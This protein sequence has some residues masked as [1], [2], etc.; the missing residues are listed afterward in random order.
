MNVFPNTFKLQPKMTIGLG[1]PWTDVF[2]VFPDIDK[3]KYVHLKC[4]QAPSEGFLE[5]TYSQANATTAITAVVAAGAVSEAPAVASAAP[6]TAAPT[7]EPSKAPAAM[8]F[9]PLVNNAPVAAPK[10]TKKG[11]TSGDPHFK[12]WSGKQFDFHGQYTHD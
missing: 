5:G 6:I 12:M 4:D 3:D 11:G 2:C 9:A 10:A 1:P 7:H 8:V